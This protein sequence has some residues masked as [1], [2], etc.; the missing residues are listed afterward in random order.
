MT[1]RQT[2]ADFER[3]AE[4]SYAAMYEVQP[5][6]AK[7]C[8]DD[9]RLHLRRAIEAAQGDGLADEAARLTGRLEHL[10]NVYNTQFRSVGR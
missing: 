1:G 8:Y 4:T 5:Y 3:L 9:A 6:L 2:F 10:E 7:D